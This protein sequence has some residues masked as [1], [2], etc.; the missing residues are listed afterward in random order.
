MPDRNSGSDTRRTRMASELGPLMTL[1]VVLHTRKHSCRY[2]ATGCAVIL[3]RQDLCV[4]SIPDWK[5]EGGV[6]Q[7]SLYSTRM[8]LTEY[9][10][11]S[12][13]TIPCQSEYAIYPKM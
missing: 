3:G 5:T 11:L 13:P 9:D 12:T 7:A 4:L 8:I 2:N 10:A 6:T 1:L